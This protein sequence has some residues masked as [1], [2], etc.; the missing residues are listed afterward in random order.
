[1]TDVPGVNDK[2]G[3]LI[4][5]LTI[6]EAKNLISSGVITGGMIPKKYLIRYIMSKRRCLR[7]S[8]N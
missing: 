8:D 5:K 4:E 7:C 3:K 2:F 1:M 6:S